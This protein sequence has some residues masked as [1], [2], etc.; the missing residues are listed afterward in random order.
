MKESRLASLHSL[1]PNPYIGALP[2][3]REITN[4]QSPFF[5]FFNLGMDHIIPLPPIDPPY[6]CRELVPRI[7]K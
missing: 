1:G 5:I 7:D 4:V 3:G 2:T 6:F